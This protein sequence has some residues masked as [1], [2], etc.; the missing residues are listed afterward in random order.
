[1]TDRPLATLLADTKGRCEAGPLLIRKNWRSLLDLTRR[2]LNRTPYLKPTHPSPWL[3]DRNTG[4]SKYSQILLDMP[5]ARFL[6]NNSAV[7]RTLRG[8]EQ[9]IPPDPSIKNWLKENRPDVVVGSPCIYARQDEAEYLKAAHSL[10]IP[11]ITALFSWDH[12]LTKSTFHILPDWLLVWNQRL[13]TDAVNFHGVPEDRLFLTGAPHFDKWFQRKPALDYNEFCR[14]VGLDP[15]RRYVA[16][17]CSALRGDETR[18]VREFVNSLRQKPETQELSVLI[19]PYPSK[20]AIW[21]NFEMENV[22][23]WPKAGTIPDTP[24]TMNDYYHTLYHGIAVAGISTTAF[25]E[26][27]VIDKPCVAIM[28]EQYRYEHSMGHFRYLLDADF[29]EVAHSTDESAM[30]LGDILKGIDTKAEQRRCFVTEFTRPW[31]NQHPASSIM[32]RAIESVAQGRS[33]EQFELNAT[34]KN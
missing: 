17:L 27:A 7:Q 30:L 22:V 11:T 15:G 34:T 24:E 6:L 16:Y 3:V 25:L 1:M 8:I 26:A 23:I 10:G 5:P 31:G 33:L 29:L 28:T 9:I 4:F 14:Q 13:A 12:L 20:A 32:A 19:R 21:N 18:F 2:L